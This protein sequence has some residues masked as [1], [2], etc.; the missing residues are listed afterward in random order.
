M[1]FLIIGEDKVILL[2]NNFRYLCQAVVTIVLLATWPTNGFSSS[3]YVGKSFEFIKTAWHNFTATVKE[4]ND[5]E[6]CEYEM[7]WDAEGTMHLIKKA[8]SKVNLSDVTRTVP[9]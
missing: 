6:D 4:K 3:G 7:V 5:E 1:D 8:V 9:R 2:R